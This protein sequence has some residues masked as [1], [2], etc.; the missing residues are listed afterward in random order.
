MIISTKHLLMSAVA[1]AL[2]GQTAQAQLYV[3]EG[4]QYGAT[5]TDQVTDDQDPGYNLLHGQ[6]DA[7]GGDVDATGLGGVWTDTSGPGGVHD[8]FLSPGSLSFLDLPSTGNH[9]TGD[10][11]LNNDNFNR[12]ITA[13]LDGGGEMW[14]GFL[15]NKLQ[16]N[17]NAAE[18]G[19][20]IG[21]QT[22]GNN[23]VFENDGTDGLQG[24]GFG[25][26]TAGNNWTYF[27][28]DGST[29]VAGDAELGVATDGSETN[30]LVG[31]V[32]FGAGAGGADVFTAYSYDVSAGSVT[33]S[34]SNLIAIGSAIEVDVDEN[35]LDTL[36]LT[37]QVSVAYD[38]IRIGGTLADALG[39][40][41]GPALP[42]DTDGDGD[43][44]DADLGTAIANYTGPQS[45]GAGSKTAAEGDTDGDG[46]VDDA[47]LGAAF[48]AYTGPIASA[49]PEPTSLALIGL[50]GL[51]L[52]RRRR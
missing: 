12:P 20:V 35:A 41:G 6:P 28:W 3:Y 2:I 27:G 37:R 51:A 14:F 50:G 48:A 31:K 7:V 52:I 29:Q 26:T 46:D 40:D 22:L 21:N 49:V 38:E 24:F 42:G 13:A 19:L 5:G 15:A 11:N 9:V 33:D 23:R 32:E 44:D 30:L 4:F 25:P 39:L 8:L 17:F 18:G 34:E 47:D 1:A 43:V 16:N 45:P 36:N 10:T